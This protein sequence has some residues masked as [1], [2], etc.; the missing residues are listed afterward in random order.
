MR[1]GCSLFPYMFVICK[2]VLSNM[3]DKGAVNRDIG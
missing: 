3:I 1:Q 2:N